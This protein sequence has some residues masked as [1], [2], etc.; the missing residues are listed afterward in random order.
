MDIRSKVKVRVKRSIAGMSYAP[1]SSAPLVVFSF[2][3]LF[4]NNL[5]LVA[6]TDSQFGKQ[7]SKDRDVSHKNRKR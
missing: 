3:R 6:F 1:L 4:I 2:I 5:L 7:F